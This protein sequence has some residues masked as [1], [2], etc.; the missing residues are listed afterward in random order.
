MLTC[1]NEGQ[2]IETLT[3]HGT[4]NLTYLS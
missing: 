3:N 4:P 1:Q 2:K